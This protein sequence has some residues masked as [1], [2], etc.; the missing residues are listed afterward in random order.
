MITIL[1]LPVVALLV[2]L[3]TSI[4]SRLNISYGQADLVLVF[5]LAWSLQE[6]NQVGIWWALLA[7]LLMSF[8]SAVP[9][10]GYLFG[11]VIVTL[12]ALLARKRL[13]N[14]PIITMVVLTFVGTVLVLSI[15]FVLISFTQVSLPVMDSITKIILPSSAMNMVLSI[16]V[17]IIVRDLASTVYPSMQEE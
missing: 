1:G 17:F 4:I 6:K 8:L 10:Y 15:S 9:M 16:P 12:L 3:Q 7:G 5:L 2:I 13:W 14:V 11:Y